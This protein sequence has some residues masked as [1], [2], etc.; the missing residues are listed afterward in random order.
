VTRVVLSIQ[1]L[2]GP[3]VLLASRISIDR[4]HSDP[5]ALTASLRP[6]EL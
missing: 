4:I 5:A 3:L 1:T 6:W 2:S